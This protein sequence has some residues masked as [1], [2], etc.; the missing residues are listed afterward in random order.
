MTITKQTVA[1]KLA[2]YFHHDLTLGQPVAR[3][4]RREGRHARATLL[5]AMA[6]GVVDAHD[7]PPGPLSLPRFRGHRGYAASALLRR[8][9]SA[10]FGGL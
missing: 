5:L 1:E 7:L 6:D 3:E 8:S 10:S 4:R 2:A 9:A